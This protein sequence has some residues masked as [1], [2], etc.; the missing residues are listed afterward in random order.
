MSL[1]L[2]FRYVVLANFLKCQSLAGSPKANE[3]TQ[4]SGARVRDQHGLSSSARL[5]S[6]DWIVFCST[7]I[8]LTTVT[9][10]SSPNLLLEHYMHTM[11]IWDGA[12]PVEGPSDSDAAMYAS[13]SF[14][15]IA[16]AGPPA[17]PLEFPAPS[18]HRGTRC[19]SVALDHR[20]GRIYPVRNVLLR[21]S[22]TPQQAYLIKKTISK[23]V[24]GV[25]RLCVI[26]KRRTTQHSEMNETNGR[27]RHAFNMILDEDAEWE[28]TE[29][30]A[31]VKVRRV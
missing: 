3:T 11:V 31:V 15:S 23:S 30:L 6:D 4:K 25:I 29:E 17:R 28:S 12:F 5:V 16:S 1:N 22:G 2:I 18:V 9:T 14:D 20:T 8:D 13:L 10:I 24:Y 27:R 7:A 26:L 19:S 21:L